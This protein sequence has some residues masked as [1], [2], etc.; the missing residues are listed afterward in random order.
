ML[1]VG[2]GLCSCRVIIFHITAGVEPPPYGFILNLFIVFPVKNNIIQINKGLQNAIP[3]DKQNI[4][5]RFINYSV[6]PF[7]YE[8]Y[9]DFY[10]ANACN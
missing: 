10:T 3:R 5:K 4:C 9:N 6:C 7:Y 2:Q 1:P 8:Q